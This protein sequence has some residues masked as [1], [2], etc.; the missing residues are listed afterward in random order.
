[1]TVRHML[2][3]KPP[4]DILTIRPDASVAEATKVLSERRIGA[5]IVSR[6]GQSLD[7]MLSERDIVRELGRRGDGCLR[8]PVSALM[9]AKVTTVGPE[10]SAVE[11]MTRM[12]EGRFRHLPVIED[13]RMIGVISIGDVVKHRMEEVERE[14]VA[15][16]EMIVGHG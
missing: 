12:T 2:R 13:G 3:S 4:G 6:D 7:G 10:D 16:T 11:A 5:L 1:M 15:L 9:T 8:D 14:N